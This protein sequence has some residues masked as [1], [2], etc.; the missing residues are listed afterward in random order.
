FRQGLKQIVANV[1]EQARI[2]FAAAGGNSG[3]GGAAGGGGGGGGGGGA[4]ATGGATSYSY[5]RSYRT[6]SGGQ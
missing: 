1:E 6:T 3:G 2:E 5:S 4:A